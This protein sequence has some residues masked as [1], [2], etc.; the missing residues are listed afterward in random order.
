MNKQ[1][2]LAKYSEYSQKKNHNEIVNMILS[3]NISNEYFLFL[4]KKICFKN[5]HKLLKKLY[6]KKKIDFSVDNFILIQEAHYGMAGNVI[7]FIIDNIEDE[8]LDSAYEIIRYISANTTLH[9][10][11]FN[12]RL[13]SFVLLF[14][15]FPYE[16]YIAFYK[17][18]GPMVNEKTFNGMMK[19]LFFS[20]EEKNFELI[21]EIFTTEVEF[22]ELMFEKFYEKYPKKKFF[23]LS[24]ACELSSTETASKIILDISS[25]E[26]CSNKYGLFQQVYRKIMKED[27]EKNYLIFDMLLNKVSK[28]IKTKILKILK[29]S[30]HLRIRAK[31]EN[32]KNFEQ[33]YYS[34]KRIH[35]Q[36]STIDSFSTI[37]SDFD[38]YSQLLGG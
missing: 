24:L 6:L 34:K 3:A 4:L 18:W 37:D 30:I 28:G 36:S 38:D 32:V 31:E 21:Q 7:E 11:I 8:K 22:R 16:E 10:L 13:F 19:L 27:D 25:T 26:L 23:I 14:N 2:L 29:L 5:Q 12:M 15:I 35:F 9:K 20:A 33:R 17:N 1:Q